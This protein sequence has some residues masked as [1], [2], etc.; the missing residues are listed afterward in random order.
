MH[1]TRLILIGLVALLLVAVIA[2]AVYVK[3]ANNR[4]LDEL[5]PAPSVSAQ[6]FSTNALAGSWT[7]TAPSA[8]GYRVDEVLT[9]Q[10]V[11]VV[12]RT[13]SVSGSAEVSSTELTSVKLSVDLA[14]VETDRPNRDDAFRELLQVTQHP[15][16]DFELTS[17][18]ALSAGTVASDNLSA[19]YELDG[20]LTVAGVT[21]EV[22]AHVTVQNVADSGLITGTIPIT[23]EDFGISAPN[24]GFVQVEDAG[25]IEFSLTL[26]KN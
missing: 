19:D 17:P 13:S 9:G 18:V 3:V 2:I 23:F 1:K 26:V 20:N 8:A 5:S 24:L 16:A 10:D 6:E 21:K 15:S 25:T 7:V 12:G 14:S 22:T 4:A 11:T